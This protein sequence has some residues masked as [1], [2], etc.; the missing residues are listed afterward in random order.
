M[1]TVPR[2]CKIDVT[3]SIGVGATSDYEYRPQIRVN[4][5]VVISHEPSAA[6]TSAGGRAM[7]RVVRASVELAAGTNIVSGGLELASGAG[8]IVA[9]KGAIITASVPGSIAVR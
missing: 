9:V 8:Y 1:F 6:L 7:N 4:G 5:T 2:A 3:F